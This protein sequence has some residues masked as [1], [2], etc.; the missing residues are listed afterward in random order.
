MRLQDDR[1][2]W[3]FAGWHGVPFNWCEHHTELFLPWH[4]AYL[5]Y[6]ELALHEQVRVS[7][8]RGGTGPP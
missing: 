2:F 5:Y 3:Y 4:R 7:R 6:F 1:G 8:C